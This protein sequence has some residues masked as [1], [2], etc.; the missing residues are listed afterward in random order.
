MNVMQYSFIENKVM[1]VM[2]YSFIENKAMNVMQY[3]FIENKA[4]N[5]MHN[6]PGFFKL[7]IPVNLRIALQSQE[8]TFL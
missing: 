5:V 1:N 3:S 2:Q 4:I 6:Q 8:D 7:E